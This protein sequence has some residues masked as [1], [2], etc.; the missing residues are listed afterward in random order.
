[1]RRIVIIPLIVF[2]LIGALAAGWLALARLLAPERIRRFAESAATQALGRQVTIQG[3]RFHLW[4]GFLLEQVVVSEAAGYGQTPF[5]EVERISGGFLL[6]PL[7][8]E[9]QLIIPTLRILRPRIRLIQSADG[10][11]NIQELLPKK[12][13]E[14]PEEEKKPPLQVL[15]PKILL[16]GGHLRIQPQPGPW[17]EQLQLENVDAEFHLSLQEK[18][19]GSIKGTLQSS[20]PYPILLEGHYDLKERRY[21]V[22]LDT[23]FA[24]EALREYLPPSA[25]DALRQL[26]GSTAI[27]LELSGKPEGPL[28]AQGSLE[29]QG[30]RVEFPHPIRTGWTTQPQDTLQAQGNLQLHL[31]GTVPWPPREAFWKKMRYRAVLNGCEAT[32]LPFVSSLQGMVGEIQLD[33]DG[34]RTEQLKASLPSGL[35]FTLSG[36]VQSDPAQTV[37][38][39]LESRFSPRQ[40]KPLLPPDE[41]LRP[42]EEATG[43]IEL[44][45]TGEGRL[46]PAVAIRPVGSLQLH[47]VCLP[48]PQTSPLPGLG[49]IQEISGEIRLSAEGLQTEA[50]TARLPSGAALSLEGS[51]ANNPGRSTTFKIQTSLP[52]EEILAYLGPDSAVAQ[53]RDLAGS[54]DLTI[55]GS[56]ELAPTPTLAPVVT[57]TLRD[58]SLTLP[59]GQPLRGTTGQIRLHLD[60]AT[61]SGLQGT[62]MDRPLRLEGALVNFKQPEIDAEVGWGDLSAKLQLT[63]GPQRIRLHSLAG[64]LGDGTFRALGEVDR[65]T[66][67]PEQPDAKPVWMGN[68][69]MECDLQAKALESLL[70]PPPPWWNTLKPQGRIAA[71]AV[72]KG[73]LSQPRA[74][75]LDLKADSRSL[76]LQ[77]IPL[78]EIHLEFRQEA[79]RLW[80]RETQARLGEG[81]ITLSAAAQRN[82]ADLPWEGSLQMQEVAL[83]I[84]AQALQWKASNLSGKL[85]LEWKGQ[86]QG[87][88]RETW[89][90]PGAVQIREGR[91]LELPFLGPFASILG[92]S[93]MER[94]IFEEA[95]GAF[96]LADGEVRTQNLQ[97]HAAQATLLI[98]GSGGFLQGI[99]SPIRWRITPQWRRDSDQKG[100]RS[101]LEQVIA[102]GTRLL[103]G[104]IQVTGTWK[105]HNKTVV[106]K[107]L[108]GTSEENLLDLPALLKDIF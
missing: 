91:I 46:K 69:F 2:L 3:A 27:H 87:M 47:A 105:E 44:H 13:K 71:R 60:L 104:E 4:H 42:L 23:A 58:V 84:L 34:F 26:E 16:V 97:L 8:K 103:A 52:A 98:Q 95:Q 102:T 21:Q 38:F 64:R 18:I 28:A 73:D 40:L 6:L 57:A 79:D 82:G 74:W 59:N 67:E 20:P 51:L 22:R 77:G 17:L 85:S 1:M 96:T 14:T 10:R 9:R 41:R 5:L 48:L 53:V 76:T 29:A 66:P 24:L 83:E 7:F 68:L 19:E 56:G 32:P 106:P 89:K 43:E 90:G 75:D 31:E 101:K 45:L 92:L 35:P 63:A 30:F 36:T 12:P 15:T 62:F 86:G 39:V 107:P 50:L 65:V 72:L 61:F 37:S 70:A 108:T 11:W 49:R 33:S 93:N 100:K 55:I 88:K 78:K 81:W 25:S 54:V 99:E 94:F 80:L